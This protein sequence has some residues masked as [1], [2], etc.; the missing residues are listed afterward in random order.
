MVF[1]RQTRPVSLFRALLMILFIAVCGAGVARASVAVLLEMPYGGMAATFNPTG[2]VALYFDHVCA[3]SP[4]QLRPCAPG[5]LGVVLSRYDG[6]GKVDWVAIPL[7]PYLYSV[8]SA[9]D[10]PATM[11]QLT[12]LRM[13]DMYR[14]EHLEEVAPDSPEGGMPQ[15]NWY[16]LV[17]SAF[18]RTIYG[19]QIKSTEEQDERLIAYFNDRPNVA[20]YQ[21]AFRNCADFTRIVLNHLYPGA[22]HKNYIADFGLTTP[23][24]VARSIVHYA[25]KHPELELQ[26]FRV[27]QVGGAISRSR[28]IQGVAGSLLTRY[29]VPMTMISPHVTALVLIAYLGRGRFAV[30]KSA[31]VLDVASL[32]EVTAPRSLL[33]SDG[34]EAVN[35]AIEQGPRPGGGVSSS[36]TTGGMLPTAF[37]V[38]SDCGMCN[39]VP[40]LP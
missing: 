38:D 20:R 24:S 27:P 31:P 34:T 32:G 5:E 8:E 9:K 2:H 14:R 33:D 29:S 39:A 22:I 35:R 26:E 1:F 37:L 7:I 36:A 28:G 19:F 16:E 10:I 18:D 17:G 6:V 21:G 15:S 11:D 3:A 13:R 30:P 12:A 25:R 23:K 40:F 4:L